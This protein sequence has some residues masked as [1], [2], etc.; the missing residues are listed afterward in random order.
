MLATLAMMSALLI[1]YGS[2]DEKRS[3]WCTRIVFALT[4]STT[5]YVIIDLEYP[6]LGFFCIDTADHFLVDLSNSIKFLFIER[7]KA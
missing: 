6:R 7:Y 4:P 5:V 3:N 1:G 2:S